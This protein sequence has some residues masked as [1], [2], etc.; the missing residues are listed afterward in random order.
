[1]PIQLSAACHIA[2]TPKCQW[3]ANTLPIVFL[4]SDL[5]YYLTSSYTS[6][7]LPSCLFVL[8]LSW[9]PRLHPPIVLS[10]PRG[11]QMRIC[12]LPPGVLV[13]QSHNASC[14]TSDI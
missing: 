4:G 10:D 7:C 13:K 11:T 5:G 8:H 12:V 2:S 6:S 3:R 9:A 14:F 1:M